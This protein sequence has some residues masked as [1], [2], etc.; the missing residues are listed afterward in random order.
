MLNPELLLNT[1][2]ENKYRLARFLGAG[3]GSWVYQ[4]EELNRGELIGTCAIKLMRL[5]DPEERHGVVRRLAWLSRLSHPRLLTLRGFGQVT[6]GPA[7]G[8]LFLALELADTTLDA[9]LKEQGTLSADE[10]KGVVGDVAEALVYLHEQGHV[11]R[12]VRPSNV[13]RING[14]WKLGDFGTV[15]LRGGSSRGPLAYVPPEGLEGYIGSALDVWGLGVLTQQALKGIMPYPS[16]GY[17][18]L[19]THLLYREPQ[20][21]EDLPA[22]FDR[23]V[24]RTL[25]RDRLRRWSARDVADALR[26]ACPALDVSSQERRGEGHHGIITSVLWPDPFTLVTS[27][28]DRNVLV[29]RTDTMSVRQTLAA[30]TSLL[31]LAVTWDNVYGGGAD[32]R[33]YRWAWPSGRPVDAMEG[34]EGAVTALALSP[35]G[36]RLAS[37]T[38]RGEIVLW[39]TFSTTSVS[40]VSE[41]HK[42]LYAAA[43]APD[44]KW[45]VAGG[46]DRDVHFFDGVSG[47]WLGSLPGHTGTIRHLATDG[48]WLVSADDDR[49]V[50]VWD[51]AEGTVRWHSDAHGA[52]V[53]RLAIR[54]GHDEVASGGDDH[55]IR[56]WR[57]SDGELLFQLEHEAAIGGLAWSPDGTALAVGG[58]DRVLRVFPV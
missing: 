32:G 47:E 53:T 16:S 25:T 26:R 27:S 42:A 6:E 56:R 18:T 46:E 3:A 12:D 35:D 5:H 24:S 30:P 9:L 39:T 41:A 44:G 15:R 36:E 1:T 45:L 31:S 22:P 43:F 34:S 37:V 57:L 8:G 48:T 14:S 52:P 51:L 49:T 23:I 13:Y 54:P 17:E 50:R 58:L 38:N 20:V 10:V 4:A 11:H 19:V 33:I 7:A 28:S 21:A 29:W 40:I 55:R 2:I